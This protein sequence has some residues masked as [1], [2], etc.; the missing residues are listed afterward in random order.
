MERRRKPKGTSVGGQ[1][2]KESK[3]RVAIDDVQ[4]RLA[5]ILD[6]SVLNEMVESRMINRRYS[7]DGRILYDYS[8]KAQ[9]SKTWNTETRTC[10]GLV[11]DSYGGVLARPF[12]KFWNLA[13]HASP[14][15]PDIPDEPFTVTDKLDGSLII[16]YKFHGHLE[17]NTRGSFASDQARA[18]RYWL[19]ENGC[20]DLILEGSTWLLEWIAPEN[21]IVVYYGSV[22]KCILLDVIDNATGASR[23]ELV[24]SWPYDVVESIPA[25]DFT[26]LPERDNAEGY[27]V[28]F[29]SGMRVKIKHPRYVQA[30]KALAGLTP[31]LIWQYL[32]TGESFD[33][34]IELVP[35]EVYQ[36]MSEVIKEFNQRFAAI[37]VDADREF[38]DIIAN[39][40][41]TFERKTF[42]DRAIKSDNRTLL[43]MLLDDKPESMIAEAI[44][45]R[46]EPKDKD[47][48]SV[49]SEP[50]HD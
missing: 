9:F 19:I 20:E 5:D 3:A 28:K 37:R 18:A 48:G 11:V 24:D 36:W 2:D 31:K 35:D 16:A 22:R 46:L 30:A 47:G 45:K 4:P 26:K 21:R 25:E 50:R 42:V 27:V 15:L 38:R 7:G 12:P 32:K 10:R 23:P 39:L 8:D 14:D 33:Q 49:A 43:F 41:E 13:E 29:E 17:V 1:F 44:W 40:P 6:V 34:L